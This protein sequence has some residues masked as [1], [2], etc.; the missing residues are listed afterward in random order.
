MADL[1]VGIAIKA[2]DK[3]SSSAKKVS[4]VS[5][6]LGKALSATQ[7]ELTELGQRDKTIAS[8]RKLESQ[9]GKS[10]AEMDK[11][12]RRASELGR[13][14]NQASDPTKKLTR[15]TEAAQR[16]A[17]RAAQ[18]H[19]RQK[20]ELG[21]LGAELREAGIDT[22]RLGEA[23][24]KL[25]RDMDA[26]T[27]K[28]ERFSRT[29][30]RI[31]QARDKLDRRVRSAAHISLIAGESDRVGR[32]LF[33]G[34]TAPA[35]RALDV[36]RARGELMTLGLSRGDTDV[37]AARGRDLSGRIAGTSTAEF[38]TASYDIASGVAD[39]DAQGIAE[40][41]EIAA[42]MGRA[43]KASTPEMTDV[44]TGGYGAFKEAL[45]RDLQAGEFAGVFGAQLA[46]AVQAFKTTGPA[47]QQAIESM[48]AGLAQ[49]G[50]ALSEQI[51]ALG[52]LQLKM[53]PGVAGTAMAAVAR[54]AA[55]AQERFA[56]AGVSIRTLDEA[57]NLR[58]LP[59]LLDDM[60]REFG[61]KISN[62]EGRIIQEA[63]GSDEAVR[64]F[65]GLHGEGDALRE[66]A[67][68]QEE[69]AESGKEFVAVMAARRDANVAGRMD[70]LAGRIDALS[71]RIGGRMLEQMEWFVD[72]LEVAVNWLDDTIQSGT[73][74][75]Q[76]IAGGLG[77]G[78]VGGVVA[79]ALSPILFAAA[80]VRGAL[81]G[82]QYAATRA[83]IA[84]HGVGGG[85]PLTGPLAGGSGKGGRVRDLVRKATQGAKGLP[86]KIKGF[87]GVKGLA[88]GGLNLLKGKAGALGGLIAGGSI[89]ST[90]LA[91]D[92]SGSEKA[93][94]VTKD[95]GILGG[96]LAG[97]KLGALLGS[98]FPGVGTVVGG[99]VG[100]IAGGGLGGY[101][102]GAL[103]D[104]VDGGGASATPAPLGG[105][106]L[107]TA[108]AA[109]AAAGGGAGATYNDNSN[110]SITLTLN[111]LPG[112][113]ASALADRVIREIEYRQR[114]NDHEAAYDEI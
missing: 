66:A 104:L 14:L 17:A 67:R 91:D 59:D 93:K 55:Q 53:G 69:A 9:L 58:S 45:Y 1:K 80:G 89:L 95:V 107:A 110:K 64:F 75:E 76:L 86:G 106:E 10:G 101:G 62:T 102:G 65:Q 98:V 49:S 87:G 6:K 4:D 5:K 68:K 97:G 105:L 11:A 21:K 31:G 92:L 43:T 37:L 79:T 60:E 72:K 34:A 25:G 7:N 8:F 61:E 83:A 38:L 70:I 3:F 48:G 35:R 40:M 99:L 2:E 88:R 90:L 114:I 16:A 47:M 33:S 18:A 52:M 20:D 73:A 13:K 27:R 96:A 94:G 12:R 78:A 84:L 82:V 77:L 44:L 22:R 112:E 108:T 51:A 74:L 71:E 29:A 100:S 30:D 36:E 23:Q 50:V 85:G 42:L 57:G 39:I 24:Q 63:F 56:K 41:T 19:R 15:E 54:T 46:V 113:D 28:I 32:Q 26:A 103:A 111:Q 109:T 81:G